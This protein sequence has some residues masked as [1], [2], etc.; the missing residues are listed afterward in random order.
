[1]TVLEAARVMGAIRAGRAPDRIPAI[2]A[3]AAG[4]EGLD[5]GARH[6]VKVACP[7]LVEG[8][9]SAYESRPLGCRALLSQSADLCEHYFEGAAP[10]SAPLPTLV[11]PRLV[12]AGFLSGQVAA[13]QD[14]GLPSH[15]VELTSALALI[16]R[17]TTALPRWLDRQD[18]FAR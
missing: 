16:A 3:T 6:A 7:M 4:I 18:V 1:M 8:A 13:L 10:A 12:A 9:C 11:T 15:V 17:D 2:S 14:L 5:T